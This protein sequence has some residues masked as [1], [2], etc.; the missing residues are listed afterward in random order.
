M[1]SDYHIQALVY[2]DGTRVIYRARNKEGDAFALTRLK[3][4]AKVLPELSRE[5]FDTASKSSRT[6]T[7]RESVPSSMEIST[8]STDTLGSPFPGST[9][10]R[11]ATKRSSPP[12]TRKTS[13][14]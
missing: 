3:L 6:S 10:H 9:E 7:I 14:S 13:N 4:P 2:Q 11:S 8:P 12:S 1:Q 5:K